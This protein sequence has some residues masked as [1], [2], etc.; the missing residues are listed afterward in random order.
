MGSVL[1][2]WRFRLAILAISTGL[3]ATGLARADESIAIIVGKTPPHI[4]FDR[5]NLEDIFLKRIQVDDDR[6]AL[7]P[8]NLAPSDPVR[9]AFS[10]GLLGARPGAQ[11][12]YW[13]ERYFQGISPPYT[14]HSQ[15][16]MLRFV[17]DTAGAIGYVA[18]C[19][20][21]ARV[22]AV[23]H[24]PVPAE[25]TSQLHQLCEKAEPGSE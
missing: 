7:V 18:S 25:L 3:T 11:Q 15:E 9:L 1:T 6:T 2:N 23:A 20:V 10:L 4:A 14:V 17:A 8:L 12:R 13:T 22:H 5:A 24:L 16:A 19:R 21:D